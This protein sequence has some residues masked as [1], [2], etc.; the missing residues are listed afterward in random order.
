MGD[1]YALI[2]T[3]TTGLAGSCPKKRVTHFKNG[4]SE[5]FVNLP[6]LRVYNFASGSTGWTTNTVT[7]FQDICP[8]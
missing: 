4:F 5:V 6:C 1:N 7:V 3:K 2:Y 8:L